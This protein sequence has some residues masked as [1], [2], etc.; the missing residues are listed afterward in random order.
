MPRH[1]NLDELKAGLPEILASPA[2]EG[3]LQ[4]IVVRPAPGE[5]REPDRCRI[6]LAGGVEGDHWAKGC[7]KTT[8]EGLPHPDVQVCLMNA[9][10]I[11]LIAQDR[12]NWAPAGDN[13]FIDMDLTPDNMPPGQR[14]AIGS[15]IIE[16]TDTPHTGC[17]SFV[18]RYGRDACVFV[19]KD[20][21]RRYKLRGI[22]ARVAQDGE[23]AVGDKV[24]KVP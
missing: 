22:Y 16:I 21:G 17:A 19:N 24:V 2:D 8:E 20:E 10:C 13:L 7:W 3:V 4:G 15:A 1:L 6:S 5:R 14:L 11:A 9:R 12:S 18:E 23:I